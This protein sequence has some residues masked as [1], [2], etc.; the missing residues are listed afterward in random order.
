VK[1]LRKEDISLHH[2]LRHS[3]LKDFVEQEIGVPLVYD[4]SLSTTASYVY[5]SVSTMV[6]SPISKGKGWRYLDNPFDTTEQT[7]SVVVY[8]AAGE[9]I[10]RSEYIVDYVDGRVITGNENVV[11]SKVDYVWYYP[12]IV[13]EWMAV[14]A[15]N[16]PVV[17]VDINSTEKKGFQLGAG[18]E[19]TRRVNVHVFANDTAE[20]DDLTESIFDGL[21][22]KSCTLQKFDKG[23]MIDWNG[24]FN[25]LYE[26]ATISGHS[27]IVF[28]D[29]KSRTVFPP[30]LRI[31]G[32][33]L[34]MLSDL[35][36]YRSRV[37]FN[38]THWEESW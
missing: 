19:V 37:T 22:L 4:S 18:S 16:L 3:V 1:K 38:M 6:P 14:Q 12:S 27:R 23:T 7:G 8:D 11:P 29:I 30:L 28:D 13:D 9:I 24:T 21:R 35:N 2:Y 32:N 15:P 25:E 20:R 5:Q 10:D 34:T 17:V 31:P 36:R 33:D 26:Y